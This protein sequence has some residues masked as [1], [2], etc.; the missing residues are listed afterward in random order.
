M[1]EYDR[2][3]PRWEIPPATERPDP[4]DHSS[5]SPARGVL[6][7]PGIRPVRAFVAATV[8]VGVLLG[9]GLAGAAVAAADGP[10][11]GPAVTVTDT[12]DGRFDR[13]PDGVRPGR[14]D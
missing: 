6:G 8:G 13:G 3:H 5:A 11:R 1:S 2:S 9:G 12:G 4:A 7:T 10:D 14:V